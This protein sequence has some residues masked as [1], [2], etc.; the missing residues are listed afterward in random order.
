MAYKA[1]K[2]TNDLNQLFYGDA[3]MYKATREFIKARQPHT[4]YLIQQI[5]GVN[6][7]GGGVE[8]DCFHNSYNSIDRDKK[9]SIVSGWVIGQY[10]VINN[11]VPVIQ[12]WWNVDAAGRHFDTSP[13]IADSYEYL[14]DMAIAEFGKDNFDEVK[15]VVTKSLMYRD[16]DF[17]KVN[18]LEPFDITKLDK[19]ETKLFFVFNQ[20]QQ[21]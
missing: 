15:A 2:L 11:C 5:F 17:Y 10:D 8:N 1:I 13:N 7:I 9:H 16:G 14:I 19:L 6:K 20:N 18:N 4:K 3:I 21:V 12:H